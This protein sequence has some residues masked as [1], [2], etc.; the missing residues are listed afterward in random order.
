M[1]CL[2][3][4]GGT[5]DDPAAEQF[6]FSTPYPTF[7]QIR[8]PRTRGAT[9]M[10]LY[11]A[12]L[13][14]TGGHD[15]LLGSRTVTIRSPSTTWAGFSDATITRVTNP[16]ETIAVKTGSPA[17]PIT[18]KRGTTVVRTYAVP[19]AVRGHITL[20]LPRQTGGTHYP[21]VYY[22]GSTRYYRSRSATITLKVR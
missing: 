16:K 2:V 18:V 7:H 19:A 8:Y 21:K 1:T 3:T 13:P 20:T 14:G 4:L 12:N 5:R 22:G 17:G 11:A 10:Y 6:W 9:T 15:T